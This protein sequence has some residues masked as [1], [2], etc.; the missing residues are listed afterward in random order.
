[1][2][3]KRTINSATSAFVVCLLAI[4]SMSPLSSLAD[5]VEEKLEKKYDYVSK[6]SEYNTGTGYYTISISKDGTDYEGATDAKGR[7]IIPCKYKYVTLDG[8]SDP[9]LLW[10]SV[11]D[12]NGK[13]S[14][15][16]FGGKQL[17]PFDFDEATI[18]RNYG[19]HKYP[20]IEVEKNGKTG[21]LSMQG[22]CLIPSEYDRVSYEE[23]EDEGKYFYFWEV[24]QNDLKGIFSKDG[25][26]I[27]PCIFK[28][29]SATYDETYGKWYY[30]VEKPDGKCGLYDLNGKILANPEYDSHPFFSKEGKN[31]ILITKKN[32]KFG[33]LKPDGTLLVD[34]VCDKVQDVWKQLD[35]KSASANKKDRERTPVEIALSEKYPEAW[36]SSPDEYGNYKVSFKDGDKY[37][38]GLFNADGQM[39][40]DPAKYIDMYVID[41][42]DGRSVISAATEEKNSTR[43]Y[44]HRGNPINKESYKQ[45][46]LNNGQPDVLTYFNIAREDDNNVQ[47]IMALDGSI[48]VPCEYANVTLVQNP[49]TKKYIF[50]VNRTS[51][52]YTPLYGAFDLNGDF[53]A[54]AVFPDSDSLFASGL[55]GIGV[56]DY[57][58]RHY[59]SV[60][61]IDGSVANYTA[62]EIKNGNKFG[63]VDKNGKL[64]AP[65][66]Y[67]QVKM[68][69]D[70][71]TNPK[72]VAYEVTDGEYQQGILDLK[73]NVITPCKYISVSCDTSGGYSVLSKDGWGYCNSQ[74]AEVVPTKYI[75]GAYIPAIETGPDYILVISDEGRGA[76]TPSGSL[77][78]PHKF[79]EVYNLEGTPFGGYNFL[80]KKGSNYGLYSW[81]GREIVPCKYTD[82]YQG[83][84]PDVQGYYY[85]GETASGQRDAY[86][87]LGE[88]IPMPQPVKQQVVQTEQQGQ[89]IQQPS[90]AEMIFQTLAQL[91]QDL[92]AITQRSN[93]RPGILRNNQPVN[94]AQT[95]FPTTSGNQSGYSSGSSSSNSGRMTTGADVQHRATLQRS[96][97]NYGSMLSAMNYGN[98]PYSH[99]YTMSEVRDIQS[100]MRSLRQDWNSKHP[101]IPIYEDSRAEN[102]NG[103]KGSM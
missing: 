61:P 71:P 1:M 46:Y 4:F 75:I 98:Y 51:P 77:I 96:Y 37:R 100:K 73:G 80:T 28:S 50:L 83:K 20:Y 41:L 12:H 62:F 49:K 93:N 18:R 8:E 26:L 63:I 35:P 78:V 82:I 31:L 91:S 25:K 68:I 99:G 60:K 27:V 101:D 10:W 53:L 103:V 24:Y 48:L 7:V 47:G 52:Q 34:N 11:E 102:W 56:M 38:E 69:A 87:F 58:K 45:I 85:I 84:H 32:S 89:Q 55:N 33:A 19:D 3:K 29:V 23:E 36:V 2:K 22:K 92:M 70:D 44:D 76:Y 57:L 67:S 79:D 64:I 9:N 42:P 17:V 5:N 40:L 97:S 74:G 21:A 94:R 15:F 95:S 14:V 66:I 90:R 59:S 6:E 16:D 43:L 30:W 13:H 54:D 81:S 65:C 39:L 86:N 88:S 72:H